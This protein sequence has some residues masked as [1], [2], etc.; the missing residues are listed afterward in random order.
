[1]INFVF[2]GPNSKMDVADPR[3]LVDPGGLKKA[4]QGTLLIKLN[5]RSTP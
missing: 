4:H 5:T 1:M 3:G 2:L